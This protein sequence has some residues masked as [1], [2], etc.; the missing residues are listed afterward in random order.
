MA[1]AASSSPTQKA[2]NAE[3]AS[4]SARQPKPAVAA[5]S[6]RQKLTLDRLE[7]LLLKA[8]DILRGRMDAS[9]YKEYVFGMLFLK[10]L[11][12]QFEVEREGLRQ[13]LAAN[14]AHERI[15][16]EEMEKSQHYDFFVPERG[17]W[18]SLRHLKTNVGSELNKAL[19]A[20]EDQ[21]PGKL[22]GVLSSINFN[23]PVGGSAM[24][25][26]TLVD[27]IQHFDAIPLRNE[28]FEFPDLLG[29]AYEYLIKYFADSAGKK[30]GEFYTPAW[31]VRLLVELIEPRQHMSVYDPCAGS[32][33]MLIQAK[34]YV[35]ETGGDAR[36]VHV[37]GQEMNGGTWS[38]CKMNLILHGV[39]D[40]D[41]KQ[42][43]VLTHPRHFD[44]GR[45]DQ[46][47]RFDRVISNPPFSQ[48]YSKK[49]A[50]ATFGDRFHTFMPE[51]GKKADLMFVQ[52]MIAS[53]KED[54]RMAVIMPHGVLFRGSE[55]KAARQRI[56]DNG[57]LEAVVGLPPA[58]FYGTGIPA[59]V[60]V[61]DKSGA[62]DRDRILFV[63]A[64]REYREGRNQNTLRPEDIEK[65]GHVCRHRESLE[66]YSRLVPVSE[67]AAEN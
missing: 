29:A 43:D 14:G 55:E 25:D 65:I 5:N 9:E 44:A 53:L 16:G 10:R 34:Q 22:E 40:A 64:D 4:A 59:C 60:L 27:F 19:E 23:R 2:P 42:G 61:I 7:R 37:A 28:D 8:C 57:H 41:I 1:D 31:V 46:W 26:S 36:D 18:E 54:G 48:N 3:T 63:N 32:G 24:D 58:L 52:H 17:R 67:I 62:R 21:N 13:R 20:I 6:P 56:I 12:D 35:E 39:K 50:R 15:I 51:S 66:N 45:P 11:S 47:A 38:I 49:D 30:G 33:G